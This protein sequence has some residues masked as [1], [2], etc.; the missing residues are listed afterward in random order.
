MARL[1]LKET[2]KMKFGTDFF[3]TIQF[4]LAILRLIAR[5]FGDPAD[6]DLDDKFG[7]NHMHDVDTA[8]KKYAPNG[9]QTNDPKPTV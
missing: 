8:V 9:S 7:S 5:I 2:K 4:V 1:D 3:K 6:K